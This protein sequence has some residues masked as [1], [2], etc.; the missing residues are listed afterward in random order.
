MTTLAEQHALRVLVVEDDRMLC[1]LVELIL[2]REGWNVTVADNGH[3]AL[4]LLRTDLPDVLLLDLML[5]E[6]SGFEVI[7]WIEKTN[8]SW[9]RHVIV[10]TAASARFIALLE[11]KH[12]IYRI[13]R[14]PFDINE[15]VDGIASC[16]AA[17]STGQIA[18]PTRRT[19]K[20]TRELV[21]S[22]SQ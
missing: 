8:P 11:G 18:V 22:E 19:L 4:D 13:F 15:L 10:F 1:R 6:T 9:L 5:P 17:P 7:E 20:P 12:E 3:A 2:K 14:K 16:A 21:A